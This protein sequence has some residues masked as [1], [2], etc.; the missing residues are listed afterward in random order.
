MEHYPNGN[1]SASLLFTIARNALVDH[2]RRHKPNSPFDE[3]VH[4]AQGDTAEQSVLIKESYIKMLEALKTLPSDER[5]MLS[6]A[7]SSELPYK[8][9]ATIMNL[10][11]AN[12][13]VKI[14]RARQKL[15]EIIQGGRP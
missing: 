4:H 12:V 15:R 10:T 3:E 13:K 6:L 2:R 5:E 8:E 7:V 1:A 9:I 14:H 11:E